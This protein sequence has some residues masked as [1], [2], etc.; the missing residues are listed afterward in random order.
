MVDDCVFI[1]GGT[2]VSG[3]GRGRRSGLLRIL[4]RCSLRLWGLTNVRGKKGLFEAVI[5]GIEDR[6]PGGEDASG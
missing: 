5:A 4:P 3:L 6:G 2:W 1:S